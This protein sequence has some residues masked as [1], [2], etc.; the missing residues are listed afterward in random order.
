M[1]FPR[2]QKL[3]PELS[4][5]CSHRR[6][7]DGGTGRHLTTALEQK[8]KV[9]SLVLSQAITE[10]TALSAIASKQKHEYWRVARWQQQ[11]LMF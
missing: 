9:K 10:G 6:R 4:L 3:Q 5:L 8:L 11:R 1:A 7:G 2:R